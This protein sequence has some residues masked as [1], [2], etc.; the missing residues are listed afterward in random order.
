[1][2]MTLSKEIEDPVHAAVKQSKHIVTSNTLSNA[3]ADAAYSVFDGVGENELM[4]RAKRQ[5]GNTFYSP[6][7]VVRSMDVKGNINLS[8]INQL[9]NLETG[10]AVYK[11]GTILP[12]TAALKKCMAKIEKLGDEKVPFRIEHT[13]QG[14]SIIF[15]Y[16]KV[17]TLLIQSYGLEAIGRLR[18]LRIGQTFDGA[19]LT[20]HWSHVMGGIKMNDSGAFCPL[21]RLPLYAGDF[22]NAQSR[23]MC[24]PMQLSIGKE[25]KEMSEHFRP[26]FAFGE[27]VSQVGIAGLLP[28]TVLTEIDMSATWKGLCR[29]GGAKRMTYPCHCCQ[30]NSK[31]LA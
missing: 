6:F 21:R 30:I 20:R 13:E 16:G 9:R 7:N 1:M 22:V 11:R 3:V 18:S 10:G 29:G 28:L 27:K 15:D 4:G 17:L 14:E 25:G 24:F 23:N 12:S 5:F 2:P 31:D 26:M 19:Q 8:N